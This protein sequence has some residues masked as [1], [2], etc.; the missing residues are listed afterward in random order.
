VDL[1][2]GEVTE[3]QALDGMSRTARS[4]VI[5]ADRALGEETPAVLTV[6]F[7]SGLDPVE[8]QHAIDAE[9][10][11]RERVAAQAVTTA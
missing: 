5:A 8:L 3:L 9:R 10:A 1:C 11:R 4:I 2:A 6:Q 7:A